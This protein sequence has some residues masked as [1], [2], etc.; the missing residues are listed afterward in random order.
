MAE[1]EVSKSVETYL[2]G[3]SPT[4]WVRAAAEQALSESVKIDLG[5]HSRPGC[6]QWWSRKSV[7]RAAGEQAVSQSVK[8]DLG[9]HSQAER[10]QRA[11]REVSQSVEI[12]LNGHSQP[13]GVSKSVKINLGGHSRAE[14]EQQRSGK[15]ASQSKSISVGAHDLG[16]RSGGQ[17]Q[18]RSISVET[19]KLNAINGEVGAVEQAVTWVRA[20]AEQAV[21]ESVEIDLGRHSQ[22]GCEHW[23]S[24]RSWWSGKSVSQ[25]RSI[26]MDTHNLN[27]SNGEA[28]GHLS[29]SSG[30]A[31]VSERAISELVETELGGHSL[32]ASSE[33][34]K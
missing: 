28:D 3:H 34:E 22:P 11:E 33:E 26:S 20:A 16:V 31:G 5:G 1:R 10:K 6:K 15:S 8:T 17:S 27:A 30:G 18:S 9:G 4:A 12:D 13:G 19:H 14:C 29:A 32:P 25:L 21:S 2:G 7:V 23:R 24:R